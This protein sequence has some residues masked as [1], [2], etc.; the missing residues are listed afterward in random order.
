MA[1]TQFRVYGIRRA[2]SAAFISE[3]TPPLRQ[4]RGGILGA[5]RHQPVKDAK[6]FARIRAKT[7]KDASLKGPKKPGNRH[8]YFSPVRQE[9][10]IA[11]ASADGENYAWYSQWQRPLS[12]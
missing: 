1:S 4:R 5:V 6:V 9:G 11:W 8:Y 2:A 12:S 3:V 10:T 7:G